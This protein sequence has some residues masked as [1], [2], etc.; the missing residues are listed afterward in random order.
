MGGSLK[1]PI[2]RGWMGSQNQYIGG[3]SKK[4]GGAGGGWAVCK[5]KRGAWQERGGIAFER[6]LIIQCTL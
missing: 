3:M 2:F 5:F 4:G 1:N 6:E